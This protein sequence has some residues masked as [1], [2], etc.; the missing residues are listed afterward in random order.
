MR[1]SIVLFV[2][3]LATSLLL[4]ADS[5]PLCV[6]GYQAGGTSCSTGV[7]VLTFSYGAVNLGIDSPNQ[8]SFAMSDRSAYAFQFTVLSDH[9]IYWMNSSLS[10]VITGA[11]GTVYSGVSFGGEYMNNQY[12][13]ESA[14]IFGPQIS[15]F[16]FQQAMTGTG[17]LEFGAEGTVHSYIYCDTHP[18]QFCFGTADGTTTVEFGLTPTPESRS[19]WMLSLGMV[20]AGTWVARK[21]LALAG[22]LFK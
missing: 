15:F 4:R 5:V 9:P 20:L 22:G 3:L 12:T 1:R 11:G 8:L 16:N 14:G 6:T 10:G 7:L 2:L 18:D 21:R 13:L 19:L 17:I